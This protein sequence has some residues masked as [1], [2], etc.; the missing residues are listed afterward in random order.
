MDDHENHV[1]EVNRCNQRGGRMLSIV[2][3]LHAGTMVRP[4]AAYLLARISSGASFLVG[5]SP[6][7]AG[8]TTVMCALLGCL[9]PGKRIVPAENLPVVCQLLDSPV[10]ANICVVCHEISPGAYYA[11]LWDEAARVFFRLTQS[12]HQVVTNLH[13]DTL[14]ECRNQLCSDNG[15]DLEDFKRVEIQIFLR[16]SGSWGQVQRKVA[17]V[18]DSLDDSKHRL[19]Y[20]M[21]QTPSCLGFDPDGAELTPYLRI[22]EDLER[23]RPD[24]RSVRSQL[25]E[26]LGGIKAG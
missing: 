6:G 15:V 2:D 17:T 8:K 25:V 4:L 23:G 14:A 13:A 9:P 7:G 21:S 12:G 10:E 24:V 16:V 20:D 1:R 3:L 22:L 11:Y 19:V 26:Y 5:A 18:Y